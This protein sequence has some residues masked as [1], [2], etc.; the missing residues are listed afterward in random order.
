[1][2]VNPLLTQVAHKCNVLG[3]SYPSSNLALCRYSGV[4]ET[5]VVATHSAENE[6]QKND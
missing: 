1:M 6:I 3:S 4:L 5:K 2:F